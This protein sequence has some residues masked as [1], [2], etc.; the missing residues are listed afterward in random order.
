VPGSLPPTPPCHAWP[1]ASES[2]LA[3]AG[4]VALVEVAR[5]ASGD[6]SATRVAFLDAF[7]FAH[8]L[9]VGVVA[10]RTRQQGFAIGRPIPLAELLNELPLP[11][12]T[13]SRRGPGDVMWYAGATP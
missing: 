6:R 8:G 5:L 2:A 7:A 3:R 12:D 10:A 4:L 9:A 13:A 11:S 1:D